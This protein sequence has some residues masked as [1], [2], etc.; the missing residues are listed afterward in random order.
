MWVRQ[1]R[2]DDHIS[3]I[4]RT[5][6]MIEPRQFSQFPGKSSIK[7]RGE[8]KKKTIAST[9]VYSSRR[10]QLMW[11]YTARCFNTSMMFHGALTLSTYSTEI[12]GLSAVRLRAPYQWGLTTTRLYASLHLLNSLQHR[13]FA[14]G[15]MVGILSPFVFTRTT[16]N[17][18]NFSMNT[19][20]LNRTAVD[21]RTKFLVP[22]WSRA[23][24]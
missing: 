15:E 2:C 11:Y 4:K 7:W 17:S 24:R 10:I 19:S 22:H 23:V 8:L 18:W 12:A 16:P 14:G 6:S 3:V 1:R 9:D 20:V 21:H 13:L 5:S